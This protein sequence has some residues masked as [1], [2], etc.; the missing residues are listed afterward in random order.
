MGLLSRGSAFLNRALAGGDSE[1]TGAAGV[2]VT[3]TRGATS[4]TTTAIP[5]SPLIDST[6]EPTPGARWNDS[7]RDYQIPIAALLAVVIEE[8]AEGDRITETINGEATVWQ[9]YRRDRE[10]C[11]RWSD[12]QRTRA[13]IHTRRA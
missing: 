6:V 2:S 3:Y 5:S 7:E 11:W 13:R 9:V 4:F 1:H 12:S 10:P 8:P